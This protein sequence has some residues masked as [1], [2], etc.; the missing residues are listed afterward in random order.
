[1]IILRQPYNRRPPQVVPSDLTYVRLD[2]G[3]AEGFHVGHRNLT[4]QVEVLQ[5]SI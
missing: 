4:R 2:L 1:M 3:L 5:D